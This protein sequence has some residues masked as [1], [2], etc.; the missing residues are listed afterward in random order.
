MTGEQF[1]KLLEATQ[2]V[3]E[4]ATRRRY[5]TQA[6]VYAL[7]EVAGDYY[8]KWGVVS[9]TKDDLQARAVA[10]TLLLAGLGDD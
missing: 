9:L 1:S 5:K 3:K 10:A 6:L 8:V 2:E 7:D 4:A